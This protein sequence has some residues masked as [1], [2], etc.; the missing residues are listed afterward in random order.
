M[1]E[2][3]HA[4]RRVVTRYAC[5]GAKPVYVIPHEKLREDVEEIAGEDSAI[6]L[7][8]TPGQLAALISDSIGVISTNT[9]ALQ[10][11]SA[12]GKQR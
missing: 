6:I 8:T 9:A 7:V 5:R 12:C 4:D 10:L 1:P 3:D 11:A 2:L